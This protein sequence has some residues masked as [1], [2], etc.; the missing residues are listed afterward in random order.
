MSTSYYTEPNVTGVNRLPARWRRNTAVFAGKA[1]SLDGE[2]Q[3]QLFEKPEDCG[4]FYAVHKPAHAA[5]YS[6]V[7]VPGNWQLQGF[8]KPVYT[9]YIYPWPVDGEYGVDGKPQPWV[10]PRENPTGCYRKKFVLD[11]IAEDFRYVLRFEG[12]ETAYELYVN[13][14]FAGYAEDSNG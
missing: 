3:F 1:F 6:T 9:N 13:G 12:A 10:V 2:W 4:D 8:G 7:C 14:Q 11:E 5:G